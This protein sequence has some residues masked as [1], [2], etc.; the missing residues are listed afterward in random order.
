MPESDTPTSARRLIG[1]SRLLRR[2]VRSRTYPVVAAILLILTLSSLG[3]LF[4]ERGTNQSFE[5]IGDGVWWTLVTAATVGYG[6]KVPVTTGGRVVAVLVMIF[7][8]GLVGMVTGRIASWLVEWKI[9][10]GSGLSTQKKTKRHFVI[11]GWK[12]EMSRILKDILLVNPEFSDEDLVLVSLVDPAE[13]ENLRAERELHDIR[14]VRGDY[15]DETVL[16]RANIKQA[17]RVLI[18]AD[19]STQASA[20]EID[21]RAVMAVLTVK[22]LSKDIYT[23]VE[24]ID[25]K[26]RRYLDNVHCDEILLS[27]EHNRILLANTASAS[28]ISHVVHDLID[29]ERGRLAT[30]DVPARFVGDTFGNLSAHFH[31]ADRSILIGILENTGN[32]FQRKREALREAQKTPDVGRLVT[33]LRAVKELRGN[34]PVFNP[35]ADYVIKPHSRAILIRS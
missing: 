1:R 28:G 35:G 2:L 27:R 4:F 6:D 5:S 30:W 12:H 19:T 15:V 10:E 32:I 3:V 24:I 8:V 13:V 9:K 21:A 22:G 17:A 33:N 7:G 14:F 11:C 20:Q 34:Q 26:F 18:L 25:S 29:V 16:H 31:A 23:C